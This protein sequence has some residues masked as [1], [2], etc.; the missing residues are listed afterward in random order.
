MLSLNTN[1]AVVPAIVLALHCLS[2][3][4]YFRWEIGGQRWTLHSVRPLPL[5]L[6]NVRKTHWHE[7]AKLMIGWLALPL[8][9][10]Q[11]RFVAFVIASATMPS[12]NPLTIGIFSYT[13]AAHPASFSGRGQWRLPMTTT[14]ATPSLGAVEPALILFGLDDAKRPHASFFAEPE[15]EG[16]EAAAKAMGFAALRAT[17]TAMK[18]VAAT[19]PRGKLFSSGKGFVP[20]VS[21]DRFDQI[22]KLAPEGVVEA[23]AASRAEQAQAAAIEAAAQ[24]ASSPPSANP[25]HDLPTSWDTI[26]EGSLVLAREEGE[27]DWYI[28]IVT[29]V[30]PN[31]V[32]ALQWRDYPDQ[33]KIF[34]HR[35]KLALMH[36]EA[37]L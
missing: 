25:T 32:F 21:S 3:S 34:R 15:V 5:A 24:A 2:L 11:E 17:T 1:A 12:A 20:F 10:Q 8:G 23:A 19:L 4:H 22:V 31:D 30:E 7:T 36:P 35:K 27:E 37:V 28:C 6:K 16:A 18:G 13:L 33:P 29:K 14:P 9:N 26:K